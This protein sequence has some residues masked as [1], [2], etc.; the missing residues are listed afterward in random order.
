MNTIYYFFNFIIGTCL[1]SHALIIHERWP[2]QNTIFSRSHCSICEYE[3]SL[4]DEIP[5]FSFLF[6]K[7][8]CR[9]CKSPIPAELFLFE[10]IGGIAFTNIDFSNKN[11]ILTSILLFSLLLAT[12][13]DYNQKS[14]NLLFLIPAISIAILYNQLSSYSLIDWGSFTCIIFVLS[15]YV[16]KQ[17][18]GSGDLIIYLI[19]SN[20][21]SITVANLSLL[22]ASF[23]AIII[24]LI[25]KNDKNQSFPFLPFI[26]IGLILIR[27]LT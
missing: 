3:L 25:E 2:E 4:L 17:K 23:L 18:M 8:H 7:G 19:I 24:F 14:F 11:G 13:A 9:Y 26:F 21:F 1:A 22:I 27:F 12:I 5:L 10:L 15:W 16:F 20:Y 6:L